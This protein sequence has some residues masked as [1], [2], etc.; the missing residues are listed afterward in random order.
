MGR[1]IHDLCVVLSTGLRRRRGEGLGDV[2]TGDEL[3][4]R[5]RALPGLRRREVEDLRR[6][7]REA[8]ER[9]ADGWEHV[10]GPFGDAMPRSVADIDG[11]A[12]LA[13]VREWKKKMKA[14]GKTKQD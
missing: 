2:T 1:R 4:A 10:A 7:P 12:S 5:L 8:H 3:F 13:K 6:D 14:Q 11:P 9:D